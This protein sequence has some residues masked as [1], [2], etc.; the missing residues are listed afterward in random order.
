MELSKTGSDQRGMEEVIKRDETVPSQAWEAGPGF[1]SRL[2]V[3]PTNQLSSSQ[4]EERT[5][6][7]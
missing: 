7:K 1:L 5:S 3:H 2:H 6:S 4:A